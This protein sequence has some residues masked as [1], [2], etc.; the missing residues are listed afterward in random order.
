MD[1]AGGLKA[2]DKEMVRP[3][4]HHRG[5]WTRF[6]PF[7]GGILSRRADWIRSGVEEFRPPLPHHRATASGRE[8]RL[9]TAVWDG[10]GLMTTQW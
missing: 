9:L 8:A 5:K 2:K 3:I 1:L 7:T 4:D 6:L 10:A